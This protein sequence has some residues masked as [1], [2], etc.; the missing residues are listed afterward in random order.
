MRISCLTR[1]ENMED[2]VNVQKAVL[3]LLEK[4]TQ[5]YHQKDL[6]GIL[7]LFID[8]ADMVIIGTG[9]DEW[10]KGYENLRSGF[11][12]DF[13]Q[14]DA[15]HVKLRDVNISSTGKVA[16]LSAHMTMDAR[17]DGREIY[18]PGR[19][20]AVVVKIG[21]QWLFTQLHYSL[22]AV[23]QEEGKAWPDQ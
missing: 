9:Y 23:E 10:I 4:Y 22:P 8:S 14:A 6:D 17:V 20:T 19:L 21:D 1:D 12:R 2:D 11:E 7:K 5:A 18:L 3:S 13:K 16:W 15:I